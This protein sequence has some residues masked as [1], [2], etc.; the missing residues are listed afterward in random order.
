MRSFANAFRSNLVTHGVA[1]EDEAIWAI[2][3]RFIILEFDFE[4]AAP[5]SKAHALTLARQVLTPED[6]TRTEALWSNL[7]ELVIETGKAGGSIT[8][9]SLIERLTTRGFQLSGDQN[10]ALA[11]AKLAEMSRQA[12][13]EIGSTVGSVNL[14]RLCALADLEK[15]RDEHRFIEITGKPGVGKSWVLRHLAERI[16]REGHVIV[17]DPVGT[18]DGGWSALAQ[19]LDVP[20]TANNFLWDL[21]ASGGGVLFI[22]GLE[23]FTSEERRRTVNDLL[24]EIT[25]VSGFSV[26]VSKRPDVGV[27]DTGWVAE[28]ALAK[29]GTPYQVSVEELQA[30]WP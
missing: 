19:R 29:L 11:R 3:R 13:M 10:F 26:V 15:A 20:G 27:E 5:E 25:E 2:I 18:P 12:L 24:R 1:D 8:R 17:L 30:I 16:G 4:S 22:D 7:V 21:A 9:Q 14:P 23:M 6:A 28:D